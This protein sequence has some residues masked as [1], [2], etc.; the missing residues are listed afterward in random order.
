MIR[1][2]GGSIELRVRAGGVNRTP[3]I[4][5]AR[6]NGRIRHC[7]RRAAREPVY[8]VIRLRNDEKV[9]R[10]RYRYARRKKGRQLR[11][12]RARRSDNA[13]VSVVAISQKKCTVA[14]AQC[15]RAR[16]AK[17]R[18]CTHRI[19]SAPVPGAPAAR[20]SPRQRSHSHVGRSVCERARVVLI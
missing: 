9:T 7:S 15:H 2:A 12:R 3:R 18:A 17:R 13:N 4:L 10:T 8:D 20:R 11:R 14:R 5:E 1:R 16:L 6:D 19:I